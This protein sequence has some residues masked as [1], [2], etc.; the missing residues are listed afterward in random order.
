MD[1]WTNI[2]SIF[3][4][5]LSLPNGSS[6]KYLDYANAVVQVQMLDYFYAAWVSSHLVPANKVLPDDLPPVIT[7]DC[8][9]V[10]ISSAKHRLIT[11]AFFNKDLK[12][13]FNK[14]VG[15]GQNRVGT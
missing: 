15:Q 10:N 1:K 11:R 13:T 4:D 14:I 2:Y 7:P 5:K 6:D 3:R 8:C 9:P 12:A